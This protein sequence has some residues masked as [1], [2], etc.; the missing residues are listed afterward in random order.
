MP[1]SRL[2]DYY[3]GYMDGCVFLDFS[4][5]DSERVSLIRISFDGYGCCELGKNSV[6]LNEDDSRTFKDIIKKDVK[7]Q[8]VLLRLVK[9]AIGLNKKLIWNDALEEYHLT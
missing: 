6:P 9:H 4:N 8:R 7:E 1:S 2:A 5:Y 3:L